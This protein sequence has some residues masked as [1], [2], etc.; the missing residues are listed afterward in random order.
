[1]TTLTEM[2]RRDARRAG[3]E[4][5]NER[6]RKIETAARA[7]WNAVSASGDH[8]SWFMSLGHLGTVLDGA[9]APDKVREPLTSADG[10]GAAQ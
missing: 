2:H 7:V 10:G 5:E 8:T 3:L 1:M 9:A 6:L 4:A